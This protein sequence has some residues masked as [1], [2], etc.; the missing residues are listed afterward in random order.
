MEQHRRLQVVAGQVP[1]EGVLG[2][3]RRVA[4]GDHSP[5]LGVAAGAE[6][7]VLALTRCTGE[8]DHLHAVVLGHLLHRDV[9]GGDQLT[10]QR[11]ATP[12][13]GSG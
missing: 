8:D 7:A 5:V 6:P 11:V 1:R 12:R 13:G 2:W 10:V 9:E 3:G 4:V